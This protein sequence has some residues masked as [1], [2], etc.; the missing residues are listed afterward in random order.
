MGWDCTT[1]ELAASA[2]RSW[3]NYGCSHGSN[4][5]C[6]VPLVKRPTAPTPFLSRCGRRDAE[7]RQA[8]QSINA[9]SV[10]DS[11]RVG[12]FCA[13][14][15]GGRAAQGLKGPERVCKRR[16]TFGYGCVGLVT[17]RGRGLLCTMVCHCGGTWLSLT[18]IEFAG[19]MGGD[20]CPWMAS[21]L[22]RRDGPKGADSTGERG[23][24]SEAERRQAHV[25]PRTVGLGPVF[26][27]LWGLD[28]WVM[29][30]R[31]L[32]GARSRCRVQSSQYLPKG[33]SSGLL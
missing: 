14:R 22:D 29:R 4:A 33:A 10:L 1:R 15:L 5:H 20:G 11:T 17:R 25:G 23:Q 24:S 28:G 19:Q 7:S 27:R 26:C 12:G 30:L 2:P 9:L 3:A 31:W 18:K 16:A 13:S 32:R 8:P 21:R 6:S